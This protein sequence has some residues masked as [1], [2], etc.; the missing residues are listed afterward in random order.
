MTHVMSHWSLLYVAETSV[1]CRAGD[2]RLSGGPAQ[3]EGRVEI[4]FN[5]VWGTVCDFNW[6]TDDA[7]VVCRQLGFVTFGKLLHSGSLY[8]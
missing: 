8:N 3:Y 6:R 1:S 4:C 7:T 5:G 2:V